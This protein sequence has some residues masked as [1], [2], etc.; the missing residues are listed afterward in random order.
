MH[1]RKVRKEFLEN[2]GGL[3]AGLLPIRR[4]VFHQQKFGVRQS[5]LSAF[6]DERFGA[7]RVELHG[8]PGIHGGVLEKIIE[9][10]NGDFGEFLARF[11]IHERMATAVGRFVQAHFCGGGG[12]TGCASE[13]LDVR[14]SIRAKIALEK[15]A[16]TGFRLDGHDFALR[17]GKFCEQAGEVADVC[18]NVEETFALRIR[19]C[20]QDEF[21]GSWL[22]NTPAIEAAA[23]GVAPVTFHAQ[24]ERKSA[25]G[26]R[27]S[28]GI[29]AFGPISPT[30]QF[31]K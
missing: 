19:E 16:V 30:A 29:G 12:G 1:F 8:G 27:I 7:F 15:L 26:D 3:E 10:A 4:S 5:L 23:D 20:V 18:T 28:E 22:V 31:I 11:Q 6:Q 13:N 9:A 17:P 25:G 2:G 24:A 14:E 21:G